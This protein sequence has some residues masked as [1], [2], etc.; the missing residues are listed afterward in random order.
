M[1]SPR[2]NADAD[3]FVDWV[4]SRQNNLIWPGPVVNSKEVERFLWRGSVHPSRVQRVGAWIFGLWYAGI[5]MAFVYIAH[6]SGSFPMV[7]VASLWILLGIRVFRNGFRRVPT[8][9]PRDKGR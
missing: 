5:G 7:L 8:R 1:K 4:R 6:G 3:G 9:S 2:R